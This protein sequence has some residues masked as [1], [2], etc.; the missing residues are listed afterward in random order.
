AGQWAL[1]GKFSVPL[2]QGP[3]EPG[4]LRKPYE[5]ADAAVQGVL[6]RLVR[7]QLRKQKGKDKKGKEVYVIRIDNASPLVLNGLALVGPAGSDG[8]VRPT[9]LA[10]FCLPPRKSLTVPASAEAVERL[11]LAEGVRLLA[12]DLS[13]L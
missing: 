9:G 7:V 10:G 8:A 11:G 12:A 3:G 4:G 13:A 2:R 1:R 5:V 6:D